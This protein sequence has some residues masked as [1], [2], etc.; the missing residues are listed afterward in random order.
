MISA[1][2]PLPLEIIETMP[3]TEA[4]TNWYWY[5]FPTPVSGDPLPA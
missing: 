5:G 3:V 4:Q 1:D 2:T